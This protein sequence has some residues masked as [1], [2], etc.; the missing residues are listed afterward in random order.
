MEHINFP[1]VKTSV[2]ELSAA[3]QAL[4]DFLPAPHSAKEMFEFAALELFKLGFLVE[5]HEHGPAIQLVNKLNSWVGKANGE[6]TRA[7]KPE[8]EAR[9]S[10]VQEFVAA[11][12]AALHLVQGNEQ[13][14]SKLAEWL[15][16]LQGRVPV[17]L[18]SAL[19]NARA[20]WPRKR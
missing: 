7:A 12:N 8:S 16:K 9:S 1:K 18:T 6:L 3:V 14:R 13:K 20:Q 5:K 4:S 10:L 15:S 19:E 17:D 11:A 2:Q